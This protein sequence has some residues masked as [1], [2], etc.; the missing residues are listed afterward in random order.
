MVAINSWL[1]YDISWPRSTA[2]LVVDHHGGGRVTDQYL[3]LCHAVSK[4]QILTLLGSY[5]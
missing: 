1:L 4:G 2:R 3:W 5:E